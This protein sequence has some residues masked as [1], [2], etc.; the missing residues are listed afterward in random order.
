MPKERPTM[1]V[2]VKITPKLEAAL[3]SFRIKLDA[4]HTCLENAGLWPDDLDWPVT[5]AMYESLEPADPATEDN[6]EHGD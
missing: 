6:G 3:S 5:D 4:I 2:D 1:T